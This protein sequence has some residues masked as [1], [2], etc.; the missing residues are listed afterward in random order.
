M[1]SS[2]GICQCERGIWKNI[3]LF[4]DTILIISWEIV[5][6]VDEKSSRLRIFRMFQRLTSV[7]GWENV[8]SKR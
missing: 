2:C 3:G 4:L 5:L 7:W 8:I 6:V 1:G